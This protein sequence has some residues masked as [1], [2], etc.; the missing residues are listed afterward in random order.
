MNE[1]SLKTGRE[2]LERIK[3]VGELA[4]ELGGVDGLRGIIKDRARAELEAEREAEHD[5]AKRNAAGKLEDLEA[6]GA[7]LRLADEHG[8]G[9]TVPWD[10]MDEDNDEEDVKEWREACL[11]VDLDHETADD[12]DIRERIDE[13]GLSLNWKAERSGSDEGWQVCGW[14]W[15]LTTGGPACRVLCDNGRV[16][17]QWQDWGTPWTDLDA[18]FD[19]DATRVTDY[20]DGF[21]ELFE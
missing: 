12:D 5:H 2:A 6:F 4:I 11:E 10:L 21:S 16:T 9:G 8:S 20:I 19:E 3:I 13:L 1:R 14:E 7:L 15:L 17:M 18:A